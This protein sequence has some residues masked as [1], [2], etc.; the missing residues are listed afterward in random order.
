MTSRE[1]NAQISYLAAATESSLFRNGKVFTKRDRDGNDEGYHGTVTE[2]HDVFI[3]NA[4][5]LNSRR[6]L[7]VHGFELLD[8]PLQRHGLHFLDHRQVVQEY[9]PECAEIVRGATNA[10]WVHPFDH[11]VRR[12]SLQ[13]NRGRIAGGQDV[14]GAIH[15]VHGDYTLTSAPQRLR[16]LAKPPGFNDTLRN[17]LPPG[18]SLMT[19]SLVSR[20]LDDGGRF[21]IINVWRNIDQTP[22]MR[23]PLAV[24]DGKTASPEDLVVFELHYH[25]RIGEN[26][27]A[28]FSPRHEW[29]YYPFMENNE[30]LLIKQWDSAGGFASSRGAL[31]DSHGGEPDS[32][33]TFSFH[34]AFSDS[35]T[36]ADAPDRQSIEVRCVAVFD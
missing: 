20:V 13:Q 36:P 28:K 34:T 17:T 29:W 22:V 14:Q 35:D 32:P 18:E 15:F 16:D 27:F 23:E 9:Y 8:A 25:D 6:Q 30:A 24:A 21:A 33:C 7:D 2:P 1:A 5:H 3:N 31:A 4:R 26:Y 12:A 19:R 11:N 10:R